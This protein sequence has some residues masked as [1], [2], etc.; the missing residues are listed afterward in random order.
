MKQQTRDE[1]LAALP[2]FSTLTAAELRALKIMSIAMLGKF[3]RYLLK[4]DKYTLGMICEVID[5]ACTGEVSVNTLSAE[6]GC[7]RQALHQKILSII[8]AHPELAL[9]FEPVMRKVTAARHSFRLRRAA[10]SVNH[11]RLH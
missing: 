1:D 10:G 8:G 11:V 6:R 9:F 4:L 2:E 5:P 3:F 7:S